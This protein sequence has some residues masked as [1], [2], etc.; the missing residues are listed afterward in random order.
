MKTEVTRKSRKSRVF[1]A[2]ASAALL[3]YGPFEGFRLL[4]INTSLVLEG[5]LINAP[6][7]GGEELTLPNVVISCGNAKA[8]PFS[9]GVTV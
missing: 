7:G 2:F 6:S 9:A 8:P 4:W 5:R 1:R 3:F